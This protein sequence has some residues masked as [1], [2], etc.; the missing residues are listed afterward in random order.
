MK[1]THANAERRAKA[2]HYLL[3]L[4]V[5]RADIAEFLGVSISLIA[6]YCSPR[7]KAAHRAG[8]SN[9]KPPC[10]PELLND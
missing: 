7:C 1:R 6:H 10:S 2:I 9:K 5:S 4:G 3:W 8:I